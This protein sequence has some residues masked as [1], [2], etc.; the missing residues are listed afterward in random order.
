MTEEQAALVVVAAYQDLQAARRDFE[1]LTGEVA[2]KHLAMRGAVL[3][4]KGADGT[5]SLLDTGNRLGRRGAGWGAGV[6][7][8]VGLFAPPLLAAVAVGAGAG[9]LA[10]TFAHH[11]VK[12]GLERTIGEALAAGTG[13]IIAVIPPS[14]RLPLERALAG[15]AMKSVVELD[16][17][18]INGLEAALSEAM[19]KVHPDRA[20]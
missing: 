18:T 13:V 11:R 3:V 1:S 5:P 16:S 7:L 4:A 10:G 2:A 19:G 20:R 12:S 17:T 9:A 8:A 15:S 14:A 6:G